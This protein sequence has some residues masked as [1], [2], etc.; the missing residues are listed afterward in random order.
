MDPARQQRLFRFRY[1]Q[2]ADMFYRSYSSRRSRLG[3]GPRQ[4]GPFTRLGR[5]TSLAES[6]RMLRSRRLVAL[7]LIALPACRKDGSPPLKV[8]G[9]PTGEVSSARPV[10][11]ATFDHPVVIADAIGKP[12]TAP[13]LRIEPALKGRFEWIDART[14]AF[15]PDDALPRATRFTMLVPAGT[16]ALDGARV[17][18]DVRWAIETPR[19]TAHLSLPPSSIVVEPE[20]WAAPDQ[21]VTIELS[22]P[23]RAAAVRKACTYRHEDEE[24]AAEVSAPGEELPERQ[25]FVVTPGQP[26]VRGAG[27]KLRCDE[28]LVGVE[29]PLGIEEPVEIAFHTFGPLR[30]VKIGP[31]GDQVD[32][33]S[34]AITIE[35]STPPAPDAPLPLVVEPKLEGF[36]ERATVERATITFRSG[37]LAPNT[38]Y[39]ITVAGDLRDV[40]GQTLGAPTAASFRTGDARPRLD[41]Q[42]GQWV[43]EASRAGYVAWERNLSSVELEAAAIPEARLPDLLGALNWWDDK[44]VDF[45]K[46]KL[47]STKT[48]IA[49][50]GRQNHWEQLALNPPKLLGKRA[51]G[52]GIF[53]FAATAPETAASPR[54]PARPHEAL[55]NITNLG[56]TTKMAAAA[57]LVWVT[58]LDSGEPAPGAD[59]VVR[60]REGKVLW[61]GKAD[62]DGVAVTPGLAALLK[63]KT[64]PPA[65][66]RNGDGDGAEGEDGTCDECDDGD[67]M[68]GGGRERPHDLYVVAHAGA[69]TGSDIT[70]VDPVRDG[71]FS[72][73]NFHVSPDFDPQPVRLRGFLHSDRGLYRPGDSVHLR[74]LARTMRLGQGLRVPTARKVKLTVSD[75]RGDVV[76]DR[77]LSIT[78][79]GGFSIDVPLPADA[80]LGDWSVQ[81][82][83]P[84]GTFREQFSVEEYR[85]AAFEVKAH[86]ERPYVVSGG[87]LRLDADARYFYGS[88]VRKGKITWR[89]HSR[90][91]AQSVA[92]FPGFVFEDE[93]EWD[94]W[95]ERSRESEAFVAEEEKSLDRDGHSRYVLDIDAKDLTD[96]RDYLVTAEVHDETN[97]RVAA[98]I[99]VPVHRSGVYLGLHTS[100][101]VAEAGRP[102]R[103]KVVAVDPEGKQTA[104]RARL[105]LVRRNWSCAWETWGYR[106]SYRC[107]KKENDVASNEVAL[108][109]TGAPAEVAFTIPAA[110]DF[111]I[112]A[113]AKDGRGNPTT[114]ATYVW[115]WGG[116]EPPWRADDSSRFELIPDKASYHAG[117]TA[118]LLL[119]APF[120]TATGLVT[121]EREGILEKR[122]WKLE[123]GAQVLDVPIR[124][125]Y[126]PNIY[127]SVLLARGR[128]GP[129]PRGL[130]M[131]RMGM[132]SLSVETEARR[133]TVA[134]ATDRESYRP[135]EKVTATVTVKDAAGKPVQ[136]EVALAAADEG[137]LS[138]IAY[139][140]PDPLPTF[141]APWGLGVRTATQYERL[142]QLPEPG[143]DR[144]ATGGDSVG[145]PGTIRSRFLATAYW[146][147]RLETDAE[148]RATVHFDAPDNLTAFRLMATAADAGDRFGAG[149]RRFTVRKPLQLMAAMPRFLEV[150]DEAAGGVVLINETGKAGTATIEA[151]AQ[152][153]AVLGGKT[154]REVSVPA[155]GRVAVSFP[156]HAKKEGE[157]RLR[158]TARLGTEQDGLEVKI[159]VGFPAPLE[160]ALVAE[161]E[162]RGS[163]ALAVKLPN[164]ALAAGGT[165]EVS[166]DPD[167]LAGIEEGLRALIEYPYGCLEQTTSRVIP[168][169]A[170]EDLARSLQIKGLDGPRL[171]RFISAGVEKIGRFQ[172]EEG[173]Y[174]LWIGGNQPEPYLTAFALWGLYLAQKGGH[175]VDQRRIDGGVDY[176]RRT[177]DQRATGG[178][179]NELGEMGS[180]AFAL[181]VLAL[182]GKP[183]PPAATRLFEKR[184]ELPRFG[185]AFLA[186]ALSASLGPNDPTVVDLVNELVHAVEPTSEGAARV[187]EPSG[188]ALSWYMSD[189]TRTSAIVADT[190]IDLRPDDPHIG[191]LVRG[192][193]GARRDPYWMTTQDYLYSLVAVTRWA[194][195]RQAEK[196]SVNVALGER[197]LLATTLGG[198]AGGAGGSAGGSRVR[199][200]SVP[201]AEV[202]RAGGKLVVGARGGNLHYAVSARFRRGLAAQAAEAGH[203]IDLERAYLDPETDQPVSS[204][205][206]G[207]TVRVRVTVTAPEPLTHVAIV[208]R[209]P[210]GFEPINTRFRTSAAGGK[211]SREE[212]EAPEQGEGDEGWGWTELSYRELHD[213]HV[214]LFVDSLWR[215][216]S[217]FDYLVRATTAGKYVVPAATAEEMYHPAVHARLPLQRIEVREK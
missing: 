6:R 184:G 29:G 44:A 63:R 177:L 133:L 120:K 176:L 83:L 107:D 199:H 5:G 166:V 15:T 154:S 47:K 122:L 215:G 170:V 132:A 8:T 101:P 208:D 98:N 93:T 17:K 209:L 206:V 87:R 117:E 51:A 175:P 22:Q 90:S 187:P 203:G 88:P 194:R 114:T 161:G 7:L 205:K 61:R 49:I 10:L 162:T 23:A 164:G 86:A 211:E 152:G 149:D 81:A 130:P 78:R 191:E 65:A 99:A 142:A 37:A 64:P 82:S 58:H 45:S 156:V 151:S 172:T 193:M 1:K 213:D 210:A 144:Y 157:A 27:W 57:G 183:E 95:Y 171:Q 3:P 147:P 136:A 129:G 150:G 115:A 212:G 55:V 182:L 113:E 139:K 186:R 84:E 32:I 145:R 143:E 124:D 105:R 108:A 40:F 116:G 94:S 36:P 104:A 125:S 111:L 34:A 167:G 168:L 97:Q 2:I 165:L 4:R 59:V 137:V 110:G 91:R 138:L 202:E 214:E 42:T 198:G 12:A 52:P 96:S 66:A 25:R 43:V 159:P 46:L 118:H 9:A 173:G 190:L 39:K 102:L 160:T 119:K 28:R 180:R 178:V 85:P 106:G 174:T 70:W 48:T 18:D 141:Y 89:V 204:F 20:R 53:Y 181:H 179:H 33:D 54:E 135:G 60:D 80:R 112:I 100:S 16:R 153:A 131:M 13:P 121:I 207:Q 75:P 128:S 140:T 217:T 163:E 158:Y 72:A 169:L 109:A 195:A 35:L 31:R 148:G 92:A 68:A 67:G 19:P 197:A 127:V 123:S 77:A 126:G 216:R 189:D 41:L 69:A 14:V 71:G 62:G 24:V 146:N 30:V 73:W 185:T 188:P 11:R 56:L 196:V 201:L 79:F 134:V 38:D 76:V 103:I 192:L 155:G 74:G 26:L 200:V 50:N 21:A